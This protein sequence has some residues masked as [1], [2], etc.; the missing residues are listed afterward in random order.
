MAAYNGM[1]SNKGGVVGM[2]EVIETDFLRLQAETEASEKAA[3]AEYKEFM[4]TST[5]S[6]KQKHDEEFKLK[7]AKDEDKFQKSET[8]KDLRSTE[9][10]LS[11]A[12][13]Y[14]EY[15]KPNCLTVHV[16][17]EERVAKR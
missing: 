9:E 13:K 12:N 17:W 1:Q 15:L 6:K 11:K 16:S 5:A 4:E 14:F 2:L 7:L 3:A 10:E 8:T